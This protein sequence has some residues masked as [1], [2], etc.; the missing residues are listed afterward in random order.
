MAV[1]TNARSS[2]KRDC[3]G[4]DVVDSGG[5]NDVNFSSLWDLLRKSSSDLQ[6]YRDD[7]RP[8]AFIIYRRNHR[9][10]PLIQAPCP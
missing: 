3:G 4:I 9:G 7:R 6:L 5:G 10:P 1:F 8:G 2:R